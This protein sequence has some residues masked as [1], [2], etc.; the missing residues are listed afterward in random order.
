MKDK[1]KKSIFK[2]VLG[3]ACLATA[4]GVCKGIAPT[5]AS[6]DD[7]GMRTVASYFEGDEGVQFTTGVDTPIY[8][9]DKRNGVLVKSK[10]NGTFTYTNLI[11][12]TKLTKD[13]LLFELQ[14]TPENLGTY[15]FNKTLVRLEDSVNPKN[16]VE[17][18]LLRYPFNDVTRFKCS[19]ITITTS[20]ISEYKGVYYKTTKS[21]SAAEGTN[22]Y[23]ATATVKTGINQGPAVYG[24]YIGSNG[25]YSDP[26]SIFYDDTEHALYTQNLNAWPRGAETQDS[27]YLKEAL[28]G[29]G[30]VDENGK[31]LLLDLDDA[32]HMG[33]QKSNLWTG[34][35]S[36]KAKLSVKTL[37]LVADEASYT[38]LSIDNQS[39]DGEMLNDV[40][41][42]ELT[43]DLEGYKENALPKAQVGKFYSFYNAYAHDKMYGDLSVQKQVYKDGERL[44]CTGDGFIPAEEGEY[45]LDFVTYDGNGNKTVKSFTVTAEQT[46]NGI[47]SAFKQSAETFPLWDDSL[48]NVKGN[49]ETELY[50]PVHLPEMT[51]ESD[52]GTV[53]LTKSVTYH[54]K[55]VAVEGDTFRP[56]K[57]GEYE[58]T[59]TL[60]DRLGNIRQFEYVIEASYA[61]LPLLEKPILPK[62]FVVGKTV[63]LPAVQSKFYTVWQQQIETY[64]KISIYKVDGTTLIQSF[65][66]AT[67][68]VYTPSEAGSVIV[69]YSTAAS[70]TSTPVT[71]R[72]QIEVLPFTSMTGLFKAN[73]GASVSG[74]LADV[75]L[76]FTGEEQYVEVVNAISVYGGLALTFTVPHA[77][78]TVGDVPFSGVEIVLYDRDNLNNYIVI[79]ITKPTASGTNYPKVSY[80]SVNGGKQGELKASFYGN[81]IGDFTF[82]VM[83]DGSIYNSNDDV[84]AKAENFAGF[85]SGFAYIQI[86]AKGI[87]EDATATIAMKKV[88]NHSVYEDSEDYIKPTLAVFDEPQGFVELNEK[89]FLSGAVASDVFDGYASLSVTLTYNGEEIYQ[90]VEEFGVFNGFYFQPTDYGTYRL[91]YRA[92]DKTGN[93]I[94]RPYTIIVRDIVAPEIQLQGEVPTTGSVGNALT[95]PGAVA[96]DNVD[97]NLQVYVIYIDPM[98]VYTVL[99]VGESYVPKYKGKYTVKYY[100]EDKNYN[101]TYTNDY[102]IHVD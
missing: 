47:T 8:V 41:A 60:I 12:T 91:E 57:S 54:G 68:A 48:K 50:Y 37:E 63:K 17:I 10:E 51:A 84:I 2:C 20:T 33:I 7:G 82:T 99:P 38:L 36:G 1:F 75:E 16:Y 56:E 3:V 64:D 88:K 89:V 44:F 76:S 6:G 21:S 93:W 31:A 26:V 69:E 34:F 5:S 45:V 79:S 96:A 28:M 42:P 66:K 77:D 86:S 58:V 74:G 39:F 30:K 27:T 32:S 87:E 35:P 9:K 98:N 85:E 40:T 24:S 49:F 92:E 95:L 90:A 83:Q 4:F 13:D 80:L 59:Y 18:S 43:V 55:P 29:T 67:A 94:R 23:T 25:T 22:P 73:G 61:E 65:D 102:V 100:C 14:F 71:Y 101:T 81:V 62:Y 78:G 46:L 53:T 19:V 97:A 72:K 15:E 11:D 70:Q 52:G